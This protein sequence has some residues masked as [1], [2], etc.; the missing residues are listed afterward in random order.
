[1]IGG[2]NGIV[3]DAAGQICNMVCSAPKKAKLKVH[4]RTALSVCPSDPQK[5]YP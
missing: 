4:L 2:K 5:G 3:Y 1:M